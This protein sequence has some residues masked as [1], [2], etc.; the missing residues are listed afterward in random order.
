MENIDH[1]NKSNNKFYINVKKVV[2][3]YKRNT[4]TKKLKDETEKV[5]DII[6]N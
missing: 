6:N 2:R 5:L 4:Q 3:G 1:N